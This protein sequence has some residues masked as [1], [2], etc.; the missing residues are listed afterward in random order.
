MSLLLKK[1]RILWGCINHQNKLWYL[2]LSV[3]N[4]DWASGFKKNPVNN[5]HENKPNDSYQ[6][7][8]M[9]HVSAL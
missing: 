8:Y 5:V 2:P 9:Q 6:V 1:N 7:I 3:E 4:E